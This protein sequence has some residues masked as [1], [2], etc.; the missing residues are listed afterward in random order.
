M[1]KEGALFI[2]LEIVLFIRGLGVS[3]VLSIWRIGL[4]YLEVALL[5]ASILCQFREHL[6][7]LEGWGISNSCPFGDRFILYIWRPLSWGTLNSYLFGG[8]Y[9]YLEGGDA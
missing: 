4:D 5:K 9:I 3:I 1:E 2:Y 8:R 7:Y 6:I